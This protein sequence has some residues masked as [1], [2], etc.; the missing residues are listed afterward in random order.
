MNGTSF[1]ECA[2]KIIWR[3]T[4]CGKGY[5]GGSRAARAK[6]ATR[7]ARLAIDCSMLHSLDRCFTASSS[8]Q[9]G[10]RPVLKRVLFPQACEFRSVWHRIVPS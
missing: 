8:S 3:K 2:E 10:M 5:G 4:V 6:E 1:V 7:I 9:R